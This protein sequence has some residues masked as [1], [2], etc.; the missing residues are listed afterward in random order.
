MFK[1]PAFILSFLSVWLFFLSRP[2][3]SQEYTDSFTY[4][5]FQQALKLWETE[6]NQLCPEEY[7]PFF[8]NRTFQSKE[9]T[10]YQFDFPPYYKDTIA[11]NNQYKSIPYQ[12]GI[13]MGLKKNGNKT[14][15]VPFLTLHPKIV[16]NGSYNEVGIASYAIRGQRSSLDVVAVKNELKNYICKGIPYQVTKDTV[17]SWL[18]NWKNEVPV[19]TGLTKFEFETYELSKPSQ[20]VRG[21]IFNMDEI[22]EVLQ[23]N[24]SLS[25]IWVLHK[26]RSGGENIKDCEGV[27][28]TITTDVGVLLNN[29]DIS[30]NNNITA[31]FAD[32]SQICPGNCP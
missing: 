10:A 7:V 16:E 8:N 21:F 12:V 6:M 32:F 15:F 18:D 29:V 9:L 24:L 11:L 14:F 13:Y 31:V 20:L 25:V 26:L 4:R 1:Q 28:R 17:E 3:N 5:E 22:Q 2:G 23:G 27:E 19:E 30:T